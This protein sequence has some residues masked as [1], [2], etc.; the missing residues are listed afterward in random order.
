MGRPLLRPTHCSCHSR[1]D[2]AGRPLALA[3][4]AVAFGIGWAFTTAAR[5]IGLAAGALGLA[6]A[7]TTRT[8]WRSVVAVTRPWAHGGRRPG[9]PPESPNLGHTIP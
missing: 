3:A 4:G 5:G 2:G 8:V 9:R 6:T 1:R 7:R